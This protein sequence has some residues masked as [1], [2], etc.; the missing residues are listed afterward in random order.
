M[1]I[2]RLAASRAPA[3][4]LRAGLV[5]LRNGANDLGVNGY[6]GLELATRGIQ[7]MSAA[8]TKLNNAFDK[9]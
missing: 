7:K 3:S 6:V 2:R 1:K 4:D 8:T 9:C 5:T